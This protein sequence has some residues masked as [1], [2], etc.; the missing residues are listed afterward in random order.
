MKR[1][2]WLLVVA[3]V[4][5]VAAAG[6]LAIG[7]AP[8][9][10]T[11]SPAAAA[12]YGAA[13]E[14]RMK[15]YH[16]EV[17]Q[18]LERA[19][20]LDPEFVM[21]KLLLSEYMMSRD[22][23]RSARLLKEVGSADLTRLSP[24]ERV[25]VQRA[26]AI[27]DGRREEATAM[28]D[29][30]LADHPNDPWILEL[31]A[32]EAWRRED[33]DRAE[34]LFRKLIEISPNW[35][36]AYNM[37]GYLEMARGKFTEAE[38]SF[39]SYRFIAPDQAN[40]HDSLAELYI[41]V[42]RYDDAV[43]SLERALAIKPDFWA[44]YAH[45]LLAHQMRHDM[46][47]ARQVVVRATAVP[48]AREELTSVLACWVACVELN[49]REAW[50][51]MAAE[52]AACSEKVKGPDRTFE[53]LSRHFAAC[54]LSDFTTAVSVESAL[55]EKLAKQA[56]KTVKDDE[57]WAKELLPHLEGIRLAFQGQL[58]QAEQKLRT[59]EDGS[60]FMYADRGLLKLRNRLFLVEV[61]RKLGRQAEADALLAATRSV[62]PAMVAEFERPGE[63]LLD[64]AT[65]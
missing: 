12:A 55:A 3:A 43:A 23:E 7:R 9:V 40:P 25:L 38:E 5:L 62:N 22:E 32:N 56:A 24:R 29:A 14:A 37:L 33:P 50:P 39:T 57:E 16:A 10:T 51:E 17:E 34:K 27:H 15:L 26:L 31:R 48:G 6:L 20:E 2:W 44:S 46:E 1:K 58:E 13:I 28:L 61:L 54:K 35:V 42:G 19:L 4:V 18:H 8:D 21:A 65:K 41:I 60:T 53:L 49:E 30:Y 45:L 11:A 36:M 63:R 47:A 52:P 64:P 59:A